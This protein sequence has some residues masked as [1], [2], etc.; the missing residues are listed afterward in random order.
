MTS[1][2]NKDRLEVLVGSRLG[3]PELHVVIYLEGKCFT[4]SAKRA[5]KFRK[6]LKKTIRYIRKRS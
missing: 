6:K 1:K 4:M 5:E 2:K 3:C